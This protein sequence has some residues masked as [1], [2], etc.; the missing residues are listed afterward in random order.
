MS[1]T[2]ADIIEIGRD[3]IAVKDRLPHGDF[4][5]WMEAEFG[6]TDRTDRN[7]MRVADRF[8]GKSETVSD[9]TATVLYALAAPST[10]DEVVAD[11]VER[12]DAPQREGR[13]FRCS[14]ALRAGLGANFNSADGTVCPITPFAP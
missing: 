14:S 2:A 7:F 3:L 13:A 12:A 4:M 10:P 8:P 5:R 6:M 1:R 9:L 11:A